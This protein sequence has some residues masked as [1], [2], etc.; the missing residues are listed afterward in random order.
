MD[1]NAMYKIVNLTNGDNII[2]QVIRKE[3]SI[4][5]YR[6]FQM[7]I[8]T[9]MDQ[10]GPNNMLRQE[11]LVMRNWLE[12][13]KEEAVEISLDR[14]IVITEPTTNVLKLYDEEIYKEDN[15]SEILSLL[16]KM[17]DMYEDEDVLDIDAGNDQNIMVEFE[18]EDVKHLIQQIIENS[19]NNIESNNSDNNSDN[20]D[21]PDYYDTDND[22]YGW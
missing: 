3:N 18:P 19:L 22:M 5:I 13:S 10:A 12:L 11:A 21:D 8:I 1:D 17:K 14:I 9:M 4:T 16:D 6:P 7:K 20:K 15:P 2:G